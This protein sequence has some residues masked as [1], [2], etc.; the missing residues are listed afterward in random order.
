MDE[1]GTHVA[2]ERAAVV[3]LGLRVRAA[4]FYPNQFR[5]SIFLDVS[6]SL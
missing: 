3:T 5:E 4:Q 6:W 1:I 2:I